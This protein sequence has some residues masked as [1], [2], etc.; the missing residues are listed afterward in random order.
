MYKECCFN[1]FT[2]ACVCTASQVK[3]D[4]RCPY[5]IF[6]IHHVTIT[7][8]SLPIPLWRHANGDLQPD[9]NVGS[10][11][12]LHLGS[13]YRELLRSWRTDSFR[14]Y[15][16]FRYYYNYS[17]CSCFVDWYCCWC[18]FCLLTFLFL[19]IFMLFRLSPISCLFFL[20]CCPIDIHVILSI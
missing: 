11:C 8:I 4:N 14:C 2:S 19:F 10:E 18:C 13:L 16:A 7:N 1:V 15:G 12:M 3:V 6:L 5:P 9:I 17:R 20:L